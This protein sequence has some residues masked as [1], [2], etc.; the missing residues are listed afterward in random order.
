MGSGYAKKKK[1]AKMMR[2]KFEEMQE[3]LKQEKATG[4]AGNGLV[5]ITLNGDRELE[6]I[7][8]KPECVD[9]EDVEGLEDLIRAAHQEAFKKIEKSASSGM[10]D[11]PSLG[12]L[13]L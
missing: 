2:K 11:L 6:E 10:G 4:T 5:S 7:K 3:T 9:P 13:G 1:E 12:A 8:I